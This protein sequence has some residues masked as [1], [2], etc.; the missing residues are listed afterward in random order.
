MQGQ[1]APTIARVLNAL[2]KRIG[3]FPNARVARTEFKN[4]QQLE[5]ESIQEFS[6]RV[7]KLEEA[8]SAHPDVVGRQEANKDNL[9]DGLLDSEIRYTLLKEEPGGFNA[10]TQRAIALNA[11][12]KAE[13]SRLWWRRNG[14]VRWTKGEQDHDQSVTADFR[15]GNKSL[16]SGFNQMIEFQ[17]RSFNKMLQQQKWHIQIMEKILETQ[18]RF[19]SESS[20]PRFQSRSPGRPEGFRRRTSPM[21]CYNCREFGHLSN[22]CPQ[23]GTIQTGISANLDTDRQPIVKSILQRANPEQVSSINKFQDEAVFGPTVY[24]MIDLDG[25]KHKALV[26]T[27]SNVNILS[28]TTYSQ[29]EQ[30]S[31]LRPFQEK[32]LSATN[33]PFEILGVFTGE[34]TFNTGV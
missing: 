23:K 1:P 6:R 27:G 26:D 19:L 13:L 8:A 22:Q 10:A 17:T 24:V 7:H 15:A 11:I 31:K 12:K 3:D 29:Y 2:N 14:H 9:M 5:S 30:R 25:E 28:E 20:Q 16:S 34:I 32:V 21:Q 33:D 4:R 18:T